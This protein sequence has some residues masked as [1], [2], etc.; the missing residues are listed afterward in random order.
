MRFHIATAYRIVELNYSV[1]LVQQS[2]MTSVSLCLF[3]CVFVREHISGTTCPIFA[4]L[5]HVSYG[6]ARFSSGGVTIACV[7]AAFG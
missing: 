6:R 4:I 7:L 2:V 5:M 3:V 1:P